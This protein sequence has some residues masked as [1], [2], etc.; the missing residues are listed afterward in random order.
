M[1]IDELVANP[2]ESITVEIKDWIDPRSDHGVVED[3]S[4]ELLF[5]RS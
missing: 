3:L 5:G 4:D 1:Y 2:R